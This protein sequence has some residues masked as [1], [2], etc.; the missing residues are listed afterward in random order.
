MSFKEKHQQIFTVGLTG[1]IGAGKSTVGRV[2]ETLGIPRFDADKYA[3][4]IYVNSDAVRMSV[5]DRFGEEVGVFNEAGVSVD[6]NRSA[7]ASKVF[8]S[9][10]D[11]KFLNELVHPAVRRGY[12]V[13]AKSLPSRTYYAIREAAILFE[14]GADQGCDMVIN[15]EAKDNLRIERVMLR[16]EVSEE[17]I[18]NR[19]AQQLSN[20]ERKN[21]AD[22][23]IFNNPN[24]LL[25]PKVIEIHE[26]IKNRS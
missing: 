24:D 23:T 20:D 15:V 14:S 25:L 17:H 1:G 8:N 3:H 9:E 22:F 19:M 26:K 10:E 16:D 4:Q 2:F 18:R 13:W 12:E 11:L 21:R 7:L 6:I 5:I